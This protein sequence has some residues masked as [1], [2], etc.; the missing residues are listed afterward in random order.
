MLANTASSSF[1]PLVLADGETDLFV[2]APE[3]TVEH[4]KG[5]LRLWVAIPNAVAGIRPLER[6]L[7]IV[8]DEMPRHRLP[9]AGHGRLHDGGRQGRPL[10]VLRPVDLGARL[11]LG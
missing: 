5:W 2:V 3:E 7:L 10:L 9:Q 1:D 11:H 4:V 6:D 8:I